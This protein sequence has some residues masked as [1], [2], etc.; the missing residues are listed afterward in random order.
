MDSNQWRILVK[1]LMNSQRE[2]EFMQLGDIL[3][4]IKDFSMELVE[5]LTKIP[6]HGSKS[7]SSHLCWALF[8]CL[9]QNDI[10]Y[11]STLLLF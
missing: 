6:N 8:V 10:I 5:I 2:K 9:I 11:Q 1:N 3:V 4:L 7:S